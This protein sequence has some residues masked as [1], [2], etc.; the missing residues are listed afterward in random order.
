MTI[1]LRSDTVTTPSPAMREAMARA[2][3][4]DDGWREDPTVNRLE[5]LV[6][7]FTGKPAA[8]LVPSGTMGN[9]SSLLAHC[10][11]GHEVILGSDSHIVHYEAG[12]ASA[13][14]GLVLHTVPNQPDGTM[15]VDAVAGAIRPRTDYYAPAG[16]ICLE[17]THNRC[18]GVIPPPEHFAEVAEVARRHGLPVH[19]DGA[20]IFNASVARGLPVTAWVDYASSVQL[21]FSKGLSAP[22]GSAVAGGAAFVARVRQVRKMLG[23]GMR[24]AG[25]IAA[26]AIVGLTEMVA[27]LSDDHANAR[28][29]AEGLAR[30]PGIGLDLASVQTNIVIFTLEDPLEGP[31]FVEAAAREGVLLVEMGGRRLRAVTHYGIDADDCRRAVEV[32]ASALEQCRRTQG[33]Q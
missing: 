1:D 28:L 9:L 32:C 6:A 13:L 20:R 16:V 11:R 3:V 25:V 27:R 14:G 5:A 23:G 19:L 7:D 18:G 31:R 21:C 24:Q 8:I 12:G 33:L 10:Q 30:L 15:P 2:E 17:N 26:A 29:F 22:V 4:G